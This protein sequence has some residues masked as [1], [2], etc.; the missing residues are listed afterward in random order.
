MKKWA[1]ISSQRVNPSHDLRLL[2]NIGNKV[3][4]MEPSLQTLM[5]RVVY[6][7]GVAKGKETYG[8]EPRLDSG[9][10]LRIHNVNDAFTYLEEMVNYPESEIKNEINYRGSTK[11]GELHIYGDRKTPMRWVPSTK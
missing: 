3:V 2:Y 9:Y 7:R 11:L 1:Q 10:P 8:T 5:G 4:G 6:G